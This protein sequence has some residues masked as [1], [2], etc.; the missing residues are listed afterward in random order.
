MALARPQDHHKD[1]QILRYESDNIGVDGYK[2]N[3]ETS[4]GMSRHEEGELK[5]VGTEQEALV[6][7]GSFT[8][9]DAEGH[10]YTINF[11]ADENGYQ[12]EGA[13]LVH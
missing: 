13:H 11:V 5:N 7:R 9:K 12:P 3:F 1:A 2:F 6:V 10:E 4:D 8:W